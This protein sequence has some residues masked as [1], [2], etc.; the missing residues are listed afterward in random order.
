MPEALV[1]K[2]D[3][4][5]A[6]LP[7]VSGRNMVELPYPSP[8]SPTVLYFCE[9]CL[10]LIDRR[11]IYESLDSLS[12]PWRGKANSNFLYLLEVLERQARRRRRIRDGEEDTGER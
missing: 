1:T 12:V 6:V 7:V 3:N 4:C 11:N 2:C 10:E 9:S 5:G 8:V